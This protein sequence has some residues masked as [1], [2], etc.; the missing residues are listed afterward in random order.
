MIK[1]YSLY[2]LFAITV[3]LVACQSEKSSTEENDNKSDSEVGNIQMVTGDQ[4][5]SWV[6]IG[7]GLADIANE[8]FDGF[9]I[10]ATPGPG[11]VGNPA[12]VFS[13][14]ADL[15]MS[16]PP[17]LLD[18]KEGNEPFEEEMPNLRAVAALTQTVV[19]LFQNADMDIESI[20]ELINNQTK[21]TFAIPPKGQGS[22]SIA[23]IIFSSIGIEDIEEE[24][25]QWGASVYYGS[26]SDLTDGWKDRHVD[27]V[28]NT[29]NVPAAAI[30]ESLAARDGK[31]LNMGPNLLKTLTEEKGF[32]E[33][34]IPAGTYSGQKDDIHT[35]SLPIIIFTREDT[36]DEVI[37][38]FT[39]SIYEN[40]ESLEAIHN[41]FHDFQKEDLVTNLEIDIHPGAEKFYKE[42]GLLE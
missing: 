12:A 4:T 38:N 11:S 19:H 42:V 18:A 2:F 37:Y 14:Q 33:F 8:Y 41:S 39:K 5:G 26:G 35:V 10:T 40:I 9:P 29:Y 30:E 16:Y 36:S 24:L 13:G 23:E 27:A 32:S 22:N 21:M 7:A 17:F 6:T 20:E 1:R 3:M 28:I 31:I 25:E 15:G 34:V